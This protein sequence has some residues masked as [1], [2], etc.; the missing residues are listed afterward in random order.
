MPSTARVL[1]DF[2]GRPERHRYGS[3]R[4]QRADLHLPAGD[5]PFPV[6]VTIHGGYWRARYGRRTT[7]AIAADLARRGV[8]AW[9][10]EYRRLGRGQGGGWPTTFD[11]VAAAI[12]HLGELDDPRLDL[13]EGIAVI[14]HSAGGQLALWAATRRDARP[15]IRRVVA[16]APVADLARAGEPAHALCGGTPEQVPERYEAVDPMR[17]VPLGVPALLIHGADDDTVTVRR[18]R[19]YV[20]RARAAGD[21]VELVEPS[22]G[23]HRVHVD[24][25]SAAWRTAADWVT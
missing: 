6:V 24:P 17:L 12:D 11:D 20:E 3:H 5:G 15:P 21:T 25:R 4:C 9:N 18:S 22:P 13:G 14:G 7:R 2:V 23:H 10:I 1:L 19:S 8:A 16:Q